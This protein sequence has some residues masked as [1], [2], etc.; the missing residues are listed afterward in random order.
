MRRGFSVLGEQP[1]RGLS[2]AFR[3]VE[4]RACVDGPDWCAPCALF[5]GGCGGT[6]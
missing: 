6:H 5:G 3:A 1:E 4:H 2:V